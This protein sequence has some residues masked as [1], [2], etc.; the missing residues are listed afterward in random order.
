MADLYPFKSGPIEP[1]CLPD[2]MVGVWVN[3]LYRFYRVNYIEGIPSSDPIEQDFGALAANANTAVIQLTLLE[4]PD[5]EFGQ[6]RTFVLD[7]IAAELWQ[8]RADRRYKTTNR[9][10]RITHFTDLRDP[11]GHTTEFFV[12][13]DDF[14]FMQAF[15][16]TDYAL[17]QSRAAFYGFRY[18]L[19]TLYQSDGVTPKYSW[20]DK[21]PEFW[22]RVPCT[23]H[24]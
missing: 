20:P 11:C 6:F 8:G 19:E 16:L 21:P 14:A 9:N 24:L 17:T 5:H 4:M 13:E 7:D 23:A 12:H 18:V 22:T 2:Q 10:A 1:V 3:K 15:N